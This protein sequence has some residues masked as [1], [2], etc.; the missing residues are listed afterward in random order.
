M[1]G[2]TAMMVILAAATSAT[3]QETP[4]TDGT[5]AELRDLV[6]D[7]QTQIDDLKAQNNQDWLTERRAEE[8]KGLVQD[9]LADADTRASLLQNGAVAGYDKN[10]FL[11]SADGNWLLK[12]AGQMQ[13]RFV[14][15][16]QDFP[17]NDND[18]WGFEN[19]RTKLRFFGHV[20]DPSWQYLVLGAFDRDDAAIPSPPSGDPADTGNF[21]L[22]EAYITKDFGNGWKARVGQFKAPFLRE[23][24]VSSARQMAIERSLMNEEFNQDRVQ[25]I[26]AGWRGDHWGFAA[27]Y[28]D[29]F[30]PSGLGTDNTPWQLEDTEYA[31][32]GRGEFLVFGDWKNTEDFEGW[33]GGEN[34]L[35]LGAAAHYQ[36]DEYGTSGPNP[37]DGATIEVENLGITGDVTLKFSGVGIY[38]AVVYRNLDSDGGTDLEQFG[39]VI[40]GGVFVTEEVEVFARYEWGD[41]DTPGIEDLSVITAGVN[42][43][44]AKHNLKWQTDVG[45]GLDP[46]R[47]I[48]STS[49]AGWR[50]DPAGEDGQLVVRSQIQLLF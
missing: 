4:S 47:S 32:T 40:Q 10:F 18:R 19:R 1:K 35:L 22:D 26:E 30:Y 2:I 25:G 34:L 38:G 29:G 12:I 33:R 36:V 15:N 27:A 21:L 46:V 16:H 13:V 39:F 23:E 7:L 42:K 43:Y 28:S 45:Y 50:T 20:V 49:S 44:W 8:I 9:V 6:R 5:V 31:F 48:W 37:F 17:G 11:S 3:A 41:A 24:L 14:Y